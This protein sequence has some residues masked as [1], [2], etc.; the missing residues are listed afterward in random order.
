MTVALAK[1]PHP[2]PYQGSKR[3][4][5]PLIGRYVPAE[6]G[7]WYEPF[8]GSA[9]MAL[10]A[11]RHRNPRRIVLGDSLVPMM[12]L[13]QAILDRPQATAAHYAEI[14]NGQKP[15]DAAYF[16]RVRERFNAARDPV[17]GQAPP[18]L[19][20]RRRAVA[21]HADQSTKLSRD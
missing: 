1:L 15:G 7:T 19:E 9:A 11:A 21:P 17:D 12:E 3:S 8:A 4:L 13:W 10:W 5:A 2:I 18:G 16:N 6:T 14:W 20:L